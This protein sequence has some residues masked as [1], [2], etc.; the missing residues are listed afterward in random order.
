MLADSVRC[1]AQASADV[2]LACTRATRLSPSCCAAALR[3]L[4]CRCCAGCFAQV[5]TVAPMPRAKRGAACA[6]ALPAARESELAG[7][8]LDAVLARCVGDVATLCAAACVSRHWRAAASQP[9][10]YAALQ[11]FGSAERLTDARLVALVRRACG[12]D[13]DGTPF[14]ALRSLDLRSARNV[15][16]RGVYHALW[17]PRDAA[18]EPLLRG[19]LQRLFVAGVRNTEADA[20]SFADHL[21]ALSRFVSP[22]RDDDATDVERVE[23][24][25][26]DVRGGR[27]CGRVVS[28]D[29]DHVCYKCDLACCVECAHVHRAR[30]A[31]QCPHMCNRCRRFSDRWTQPC[32]RCKRWCCAACA[33]ECNA[34]GYL[35]PC[36]DCAAEG[37]EGHMYFCD[38]DDCGAIYC[39]GCAFGGDEADNRLRECDAG[40]GFVL[41][42]LGLSA[43]CQK[44]YCRDCQREGYLERFVVDRGSSDDEEEDEAEPEAYMLCLSCNSEAE[45][46]AEMYG[47]GDFSSSEEEDE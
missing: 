3:A 34:C 38:C 40:E 7:D 23:S 33:L 6:V 31:S 36:A 24:C 5:S 39:E 26:S 47:F 46:V 28:E 25:A 37:E 19:A 16:L 20:T 30:R 42:R 13:A 35:G 22:G 17:L 18:G 9:Q 21:A 44:A 10:L 1:W 32:D 11:N 4:C 2:A 15:T 8:T 12:V 45:E 27:V 14:C 41:D 29:E 43:Y